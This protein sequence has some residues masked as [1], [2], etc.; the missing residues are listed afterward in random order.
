V[1]GKHIEGQYKESYRY[2]FHQISFFL[3]WRDPYYYLRLVEYLQP[4]NFVD[5]SLRSLVT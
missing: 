3:L 1:I 5:V 2:T 4:P